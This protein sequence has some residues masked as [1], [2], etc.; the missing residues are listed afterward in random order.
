[1]HLELDSIWKAHAESEGLDAVFG[2]PFTWRRSCRLGPV[3]SLP[4]IIFQAPSSP[5][6]VYYWHRVKFQLGKCS[7][8]LISRRSS[9]FLSGWSLLPKCK[10][11]DQ[12]S[13]VSN[14]PGI[15]LTWLF[16][17]QIAMKSRSV[18]SFCCGFPHSKGLK[19]CISSILQTRK[20]FSHNPLSKLVH[21][22]K[23]RM[24]KRTI[25]QRSK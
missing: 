18:L 1:M 13:Y 22:L 2:P 9:S 16:D 6:P 17:P 14:K 25:I 20:F 11:S 21:S 5:P 12:F 4:N 19:M 15:S 7:P 3:P 23:S 24:R 8:S 10:L